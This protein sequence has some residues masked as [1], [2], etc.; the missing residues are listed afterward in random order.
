MV[1]EI[2]HLQDTWTLIFVDLEN[3]FALIIVL[4]KSHC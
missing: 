4:F 3:F 2:K 1:Y